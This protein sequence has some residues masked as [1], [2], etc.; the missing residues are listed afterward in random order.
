V[1]RIAQSQPRQIGYGIF[2]FLLAVYLL[3]YSGRIHV[4]DETYMLAVTESLGKG[5]LDAN[6]AAS[7]QWGSW[8]PGRVNRYTTGTFAPSGDMFCKKGIGI[9]LLAFPFFW[10]SSVLPGIGAVHGAFLTNA[11]LTAL[12][13]GILFA[14][15]LALGF[16]IH[17]ALACSLTFGLGTLAWPYART[18]LSEP[19]AGLGFLLALWGCSLFHRTADHRTAFLGGLGYG[20][21]LLALP[22]AVF[23][24]PIFLAAM[25]G[26]VALSR[27]D[28]PGRRSWKA[29]GGW[30][31]GAAGPFLI[32]L[33]Y[34]SL[35][36]G[37]PLD[38]GSRFLLQDFSLPVYKGLIGLL[39]S[40]A[41]GLLF[42]SPVLLLALPG[43]WIG[44]RKHKLEFSLIA[45]VVGL[46][47]VFYAAFKGWHGSWSWGPRY[48]VPLLPLM[49][50]PAAA[51]WE[52]VRAKRHVVG[53][54]LLAFLVAA[55]VFVQLVGNAGD[56]IVTEFRL[57]D[58][59][60][61][62]GDE[63]YYWGR[64]GL[65]DPRW[66]PLVLQAQ[67]VMQG[68]LDL[69]WVHQGQVDVLAL[70]AGM[71]G[72]I[73]GTLTLWMAFAPGARF[74]L[75]ALLALSIL[76]LDAWVM[77]ARVTASPSYDVEPDGRLQVLAH[78]VSNQEAGDA[79]ISAVP[80]LGELVMD[81]Y[82]TLP[83]VY[84]LLRGQEDYPE[85]VGLLA[86]AARSHSRLWFLSVWTPSA[87]PSSHVELWLAT[88]TFPVETWEFGGYRLNLFSTP[89]EPDLGGPIG[90][91]FGN[92]FR[93]ERFAVSH[94][95]GE[96]STI[97]QLAL[98]W[99]ALR[100]AAQDYQVFVHVYNRQGELVAQADHSPVEGFYPTST[101]S[102]G[103]VVQDRIAV[104]LPPELGAGAYQLAVGLYDWRSGERLTVYSESGGPALPDG[105]VWLVGPSGH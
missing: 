58:R 97:L 78:V 85:I 64:E 87:D 101:W 63:W 103:Q 13:G 21:A 72:L 105:R 89:A 18:F 93:L 98:E 6:Q 59:L 92:L 7:L 100:P 61:S 99:Q 34:N 35:R 15:L 41:R 62:Q 51:A 71:L 52:A 80:Y 81:R 48:L 50:V 57:S 37:S 65:F 56:P 42:Y 8:E 86:Q 17:A 19:L 44:F 22:A 96:Q 40:P 14:C 74:R 60:A 75:V 26:S 90:A 12:T 102:P 82:P 104:E 49:A 39:V 73:A 16:S 4:I 54:V 84:G 46:Y 30:L 76:L 55:S 43:Y 67:D 47:L 66:S 23:S 24:F 31:A 94:R 10:S 95:N 45:A 33:L 38:N 9:S 88:H 69:G 91:V 70:G 83:P 36:F 3:C 28:G 32:Y 11:F 1:A 53:Y 5:R 27:T 29:L 2:I 20:V 25:V 79:L 68:H 77:A